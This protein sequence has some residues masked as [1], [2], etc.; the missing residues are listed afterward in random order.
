MT[1]RDSATATKELERS[2]A[3]S[4]GL[5]LA[6]P[7]PL[8]SYPR[9]KSELGGGGAGGEVEGGAADGDG[10]GRPGNHLFVTYASGDDG[11]H[12][13]AS[14]LKQMLRGRAPAVRAATA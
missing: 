4:F 9:L 14:L 12:D 10:D 3:S 6:L 1:V 8:R 11:A 2:L 13:A 7:Q 5:M